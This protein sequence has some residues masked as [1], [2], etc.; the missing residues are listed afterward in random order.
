MHR[1]EA[2]RVRRTGGPRRC[3]S[4][5]SSR[6]KSRQ[7]GCRR[8]RRGAP[9]CRRS[10]TILYQPLPVARPRL[11]P[12]RRLHGRRRRHRAGGARLLR[13]GHP[14]GSGR[15]RADRLPDA[16]P[17]LDAVRDV[18]DQVPRQVA[19]LRRPAVDPPS[20][21][22]RQRILRPLFGARQGVLP[23]GTGPPGG[24][25]E[26]QPSG[27]RRRPCRPRTR[28]GCWLCCATMPSA[29]TPITRRC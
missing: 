15:R 20:H 26:G 7:R 8:P 14:A 28:R 22:Q 17:P 4:L 11:R 9:P 23:P 29:A 5:P 10:R 12:R 27:A 21:R 19:D 3:H 16:A 24:A 18:R 2:A 1:R 6:P 13:P 25:V